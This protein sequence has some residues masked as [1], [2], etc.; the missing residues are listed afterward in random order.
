MVNETF[1]YL[2]ASVGYWFHNLLFSNYNEVNGKFLKV[3]LM[4]VDSR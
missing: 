2:C 3:A 1:E 4:K